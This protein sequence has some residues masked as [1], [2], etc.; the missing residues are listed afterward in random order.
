MLALSQG[1]LN[2]VTF[3]L[4]RVGIEYLQAHA[5]QFT[6]GALL[7]VLHNGAI[8]AQKAPTADGVRQKQCELGNGSWPSQTDPEH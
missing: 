1:Q 3:G 4:R 5:D 2:F 7:V 6:Q 8:G